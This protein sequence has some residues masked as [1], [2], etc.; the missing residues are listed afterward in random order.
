MRNSRSV[1]SISGQLTNVQHKH[2]KKITNYIYNLPIAEPFQTPITGFP[3]YFEKIKKP[4]DLGTVLD[5][6]EKGLYNSVEK[7]KEDMNQI[8]KNAMLFNPDNHIYHIMADELLRLFKS[9][10][11]SIPKNEIED[12]HYYVSKTQSKLSKMCESKPIHQKQQRH[13][14]FLKIK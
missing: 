9:F 14:L 3:E 11:E 5:K 12:W 7:W 1:F 2:C 13:V 10:S 4:M 6:L 8:W